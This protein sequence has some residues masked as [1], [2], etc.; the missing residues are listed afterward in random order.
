MATNVH[1]ERKGSENN[2]SMLRRFRTRVKTSG[3]LMRARSLRFHSRED[4][5]FKKKKGKL[6]RIKKKNVYERL[7]KLGKLGD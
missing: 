7:H 1:I 2:M 3:L 6:T 5:D 4:S